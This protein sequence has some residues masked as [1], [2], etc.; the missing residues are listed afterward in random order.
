MISRR[1]SQLQKKP[2]LKTHRQTYATLLILGVMMAGG[3]YT[4]LRAQTSTLTPADL[5]AKAKAR[6]DS[7]KTVVLPH[8]PDFAGLILNRPRLHELSK[9]LSW[10]AQGVNALQPHPCCL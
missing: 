7:L 4:I 3:A 8:T 2:R 5:R 10:D 9:P 1:R 6:T